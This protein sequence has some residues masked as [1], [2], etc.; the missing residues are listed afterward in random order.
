MF[1]SA[2]VRRDERMRRVKCQAGCSE[3]GHGSKLYIEQDV[4]MQREG[5]L[6]AE[7]AVAGD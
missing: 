2:G 6:A 3:S 7:R 5:V 4:M 1:Y